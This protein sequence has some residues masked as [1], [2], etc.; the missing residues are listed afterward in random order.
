M[1]KRQ[2]I[3][4]INNRLLLTLNDFCDAAKWHCCP[5]QVIIRNLDRSILRDTAFYVSLQIAHDQPSTL[6]TVEKLLADVQYETQSTW[7]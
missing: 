4:G 2:N 7:L 6:N 1:Q 3:L 5:P